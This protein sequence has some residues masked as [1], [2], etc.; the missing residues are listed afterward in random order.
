[1]STTSLDPT[2]SLGTDPG[3]GK[4]AAALEVIKSLGQTALLTA[5]MMV[6]VLA[7]SR[8]PLEHGRGVDFQLVDLQ[9]K[10]ISSAELRGKPTVLYF[11][12]TWCGACKMTTATVES[13][14]ARNPDVNVLA[15]S[16]EGPGVLRPWVDERETDLR[17]LGGGRSLMAGLGIASY[18]T[19]VILDE[20]GRVK[21]N[22]S[23]VL[24]PGELDVRL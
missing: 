3:S 1:M 15:V 12:A 19:T 2:P 9:G 18:P 8:G 16:A 14:A 11:W 20:Q 4:G 23:G 7:L 5:G 21:W 13:F 6:V 17:V 10:S 22:R 24:V